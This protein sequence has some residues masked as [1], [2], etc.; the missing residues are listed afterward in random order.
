[1]SGLPRSIIKKYGVTKKAWSIFRGGK[2]SM[3]RSRRTSSKGFRRSRH[4]T[5][6]SKVDMIIGGAIQGLVRPLAAKYLPDIFPYSDNV[7]CGAADWFLAGQNNKIMKGAGMAGLALETSLITMNLTS[8]L[9]GNPAASDTE[10][11]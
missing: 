10:D 7:I 6:V 8:G 2:R 4:G 1:M 5:N 9:I 3:A 11:A